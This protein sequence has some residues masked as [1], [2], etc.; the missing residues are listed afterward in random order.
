M[1]RS[2]TTLVLTTLAI[3]A[4][5]APRDGYAQCSNE[6]H[7]FYILFP[8]NYPGLEPRLR[9]FLT[10]HNQ[11]TK[12]E[13]LYGTATRDTVT[14]TS[15]NVTIVPLPN[16][17][18]HLTQSRAVSSVAGIYV[19]S[20]DSGT[21]SL[22]GL[23]RIQYTT[24]AYTGIPREA[25]GMR[26]LAASY[27]HDDDPADGGP[28][29]A[30]IATEDST[31]VTFD[32]P[33]VTP[34]P[35]VV[36][37]NKR[38]AYLLIDTADMTGGVI[39]SNKPVAVF[40]GNQCTYV[41]AGV[42]ACDH[43]VEQLLPTTSWGKLFHIS[44]FTG[45]TP[46]GD[47]CR[48]IAEKNNTTVYIDGAQ[49]ANLAAGTYY[50]TSISQPVELFV[51]SSV[52]L[53]QYATGGNQNGQSGDP[54]MM[55]VPPVTQYL[56]EFTFS[57][58]TDNDAYPEN[59]VTVIAP[60]SLTAHVLLDGTAIGTLFTPITKHRSLEQFAVANIGISAGS[61]RVYYDTLPSQSE[62]YS[63]MGYVYG[64]GNY[65]SYGYAGSVRLDSCPI[66]ELCDLLSISDTCNAEHCSELTLS[67]S[68]QPEI[69]K[70]IE[71]TLIT[72]GS[73]VIVSAKGPWQPPPTHSAKSVSWTIPNPGLPKG[74]RDSLSICFY[75][76]DRHP[77]DV[78]IDWLDASGRTICSDT[79]TEYCDTVMSDVRD[80]N[81]TDNTISLLAYPDPASS[82]ATIRFAFRH[83]E[84]NVSLTLA[85]ILGRTVLML[86]NMET[87]EAGEHSLKANI[88]T[89]PAGMYLFTLRSPKAT[90]TRALRVVR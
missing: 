47:L 83:H 82:E 51:D 85:D 5:V 25:L 49:V 4:L 88:S 70:S 81:Q 37:L 62:R 52:E 46:G 10:A 9:L 57:T 84:E 63:L 41:P 11:T 54:F 68:L 61:H 75:N 35:T 59:Y 89:L 33:G 69:I 12:V 90:A 6:G 65:D 53:V 87:F 44:P 3:L 60:V 43:L 39:T 64:W 56:N 2:I 79:V 21:F 13:I 27:F 58:P 31:I 7:E 32:I 14:V 20:L 34:N 19:H 16:D 55:L 17:P 30:V 80:A 28:E 74:K 38:Q 8:S 73:A 76:P 45:R 24:D 50:E 71:A 78:R 66:P 1:R 29:V 67:N 40:S 48:V 86:A 77:L 26:Y 23:N 22:Y 15:G 72:P 18:C 42:T 36:T